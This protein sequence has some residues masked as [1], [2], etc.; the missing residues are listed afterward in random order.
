MVIRLLEKYPHL[1]DDN[2]RLLATV[3][4]NEL[5]AEGYDSKCISAFE[6]LSLIASNTLSKSGSVTRASRKIQEQWPQLRGKRWRERQSH[7]KDVVFDLKEMEI[8]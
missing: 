8:K 3:W 5:H 2:N 6:L 7:Q 1:R 4:N